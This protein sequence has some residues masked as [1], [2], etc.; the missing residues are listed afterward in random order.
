[1]E[2]SIYVA[3]DIETAGNEI[4][5]WVFAVGIAATTRSGEVIAKKSWSIP[6]HEVYDERYVDYEKDAPASSTYELVRKYAKYIDPV[7][8][9]QF[10]QKHE[11]VM[12]ALLS[13]IDGRS[14]NVIWSEIAAYIDTMYATYDNISIVSDCPQFDEPFIASR[15][16]QM[17]PMGSFISKFGLQYKRTPNKSGRDRLDLFNPC[18]VLHKLPANIKAIIKAEAAAVSP[19]S[20]MP[21]DDAHH[22]IA[23]NIQL[24]LYLENHIRITL[25]NVS[26]V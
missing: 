25:Y 13:M 17:G 1:M 5:S 9:E 20:H 16:R 24:D 10:W 26:A 23:L 8:Y 19:H 6:P 21:A 4:G 18:D 12:S 2:S 7:C 14:A 22:R 15:I 11:N 3:F